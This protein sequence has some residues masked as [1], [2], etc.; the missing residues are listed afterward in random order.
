MIAQVLDT[1]LLLLALA[2][3]LRLIPLRVCRQRPWHTLTDL[4]LALGLGLATALVKAWWLAPHAMTD[5]TDTSDIPDVCLTVEALR[6]LQIDGVQRQPGAALL[7]ALLSWPLGFFDGVAAGALASTAALGAALYLWARIL[8][9][10][11]AGVAAAVLSCAFSCY[12]VM[13][14]YM[15]FYPECVAAYALCAAAAAAALRWR[16]LPTLGLAGAG[17]GLTLAVDHQGLL[18]ALVPAAVALAAALRTPR[19]R[20]IPLRLGVLLLPVLLSWIGA[21][22]IT[23]LEMPALEDKAM[24]FTADNMG[25]MVHQ[26]VPDIHGRLGDDPLDGLRR[27]AYPSVAAHGEEQRRGYNW[28]RSGP[29]GVVR[30]LTTLAL[31][32]REKPTARVLA[33]KDRRWSLA[34]MRASQVTPW[35]LPALLSL[36]LVGVALRRRP[37]ELMGL[38]V[39]LLPFAVLLRTVAT[40]QVFPKYLM[41]PMIPVPVLLGAA[42]VVVA[43]RPAGEQAVGR[44]AQV[45]TLLLA[46]VVPGLLVTGVLPNWYGP[47][48]PRREKTATDAGFYKVYTGDPSYTKNP[49]LKACFRLYAADRQRGGPG[50]TRIYPRAWFE[51]RWEQLRSTAARRT[52]APARSEAPPPVVPLPAPAPPEPP[53]N[54]PA[55]PEPPRRRP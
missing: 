35:I 43:Q 44:P 18:Y 25:H 40:T 29:L 34:R 33:I 32:T 7:P 52:T 53:R 16:T 23:P 10:R 12:A 2:L 6:T 4:G 3:G 38:V 24:V 9:G 1:P 47:A 31:L 46:L 36:V 50:H 19:R 42:W 15:T 41:G 27:W 22:L 21:R 39:M 17:V 26:P 11:A 55:P 45:A 20:S 30:A 5:G 37:W 28:G 48:A 54:R 49:N 51:Q 13:P 14:R 8:C